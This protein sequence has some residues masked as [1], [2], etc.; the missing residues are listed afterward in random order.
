MTENNQILHLTEIVNN[1]LNEGYDIVTIYEKLLEE[2]KI[3]IKFNTLLDI[4]GK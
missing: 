3:D 2:Y 4:I 1:L